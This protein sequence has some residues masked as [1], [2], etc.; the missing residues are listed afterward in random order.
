LA[1]CELAFGVSLTYKQSIFDLQAATSLLMML[2]CVW[3]LEAPHMAPTTRCQQLPCGCSCFVA[4]VL[5]LQVCWVATLLLK[6]YVLLVA[7]LCQLNEKDLACAVW[8]V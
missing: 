4:Y 1:I 6:E 8:D 5:G 2:G 7:P 3:L